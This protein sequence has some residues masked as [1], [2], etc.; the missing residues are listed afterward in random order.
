MLPNGQRRRPLTRVIRIR[1]RFGP[2][3]T[4][5][6][7]LERSFA[8]VFEHPLHFQHQIAQVERL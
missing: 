3:L 5:I 2:E 1:K 7:R 6:R 8:L 4:V